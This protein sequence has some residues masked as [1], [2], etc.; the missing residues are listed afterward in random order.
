MS[1]PEPRRLAAA[2]LAAALAV[3]ASV[4][5]GGGLSTEPRAP[6]LGQPVSAADAARSDLN[7]YPDGRGLPAGQGNARQGRAIFDAQCAVCHGPAGRGASA[8][9]L[10]GGSEPLTS[11]TPDKTIGLYWPYATT[12][13]DFIRRAK[14]MFA[15]GS[16]SADQVYA[17]SAYLLQVNGLVGEADEMNAKT[18]PAVRMPNREGFVGID[19]KAPPR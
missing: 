8:E 9:E 5:A 14:P 16:L 6:R 19:A 11:E 7:V 13:F 2:L 10:A 17:V 15:P 1:T 18:L 3:P 12:L 4:Q